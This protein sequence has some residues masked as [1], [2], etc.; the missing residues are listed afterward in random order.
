MSA[1]GSDDSSDSGSSGSSDGIDAQPKEHLVTKIRKVYSNKFD[2]V[3]QSL[4]LA[5]KNRADQQQE[6][7][8]VVSTGADPQPQS[9]HLPPAL[10]QQFKI[11]K[12]FDYQGF[13]TIILL[14]FLSTGFLFAMKKY[15]FTPGEF[16][17]QSSGGQRTSRQQNTHKTYYN[18]H[19]SNSHGSPT[20]PLFNKD[21]MTK[22]YLSVLGLP[23]DNLCPSVREV[24]AAY[25]KVSLRTHPD[26]VNA[27]NPKTKK[28]LEERFIMATKAHDELLHM[29]R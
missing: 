19:N 2:A 27:D 9:Q 24:K 29:L 3:R 17:K 20:T 4:K 28:Y 6:E 16:W 10:Q 12:V 26:V 15:I 18:F 7:G 14:S 1:S 13:G 25:R 23:L 5:K 11:K 8:R 22:S 21:Q